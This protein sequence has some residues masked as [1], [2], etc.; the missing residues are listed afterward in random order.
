MSGITFSDMSVVYDGNAHHAVI[1]GTLPTGL[2]GIT[3]TVT[4]TG[5]A[6]N[7]SDGAVLTTATFATE[8]ENYEIP[9]AMTAYTTVTPKTLNVIANGLSITYGEEDLPL[10]YIYEGLVDG[11]VITGAP[12]RE[13]GDEPGEYAILVGT[14]T[15]GENYSISFVGAT[16]VIEKMTAL[17]DISGV[18]TE[19]T[20]TGALQTVTGAVLN[21]TEAELVTENGTFTT[22]GEGDGLTV[23]FS[24]PETDH[25]KAVSVSVTV[26]VSPLKV[27]APTAAESSFEFTGEEIV[28][29]EG[30][31]ELPYT[32]TNGSATEVGTY[33]AVI[34]L[35]DRENYVWSDAD[36]DGEME[37]EITEKTVLDPLPEPEDNV[38]MLEPDDN[39]DVPE[40]ENNVYLPE[41]EENA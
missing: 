9:D 6:T 35:K 7:V 29:I 25:Y 32:V 26:S 11:D 12:E 24:A 21:H 31:D 30:S 14:L 38:D 33:T 5:E 13:S 28:Y 22:V 10:T 19:Y 3:V 8:S 2:D 16:Y 34:E 17:I 20:Y 36:F 23:I 39:E 40:P 41:S 18:A 27:D 1:S 4:Y 15:A 37:W